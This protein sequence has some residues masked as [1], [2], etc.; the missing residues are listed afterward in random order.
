MKTVEVTIA[1]RTLKLSPLKLELV[2]S[3]RE[4]CD[5]LVAAKDKPMDK[6]WFKDVMDGVAF[7]FLCAKPTHPDLTL[8][9][10]E[11][12]IAARLTSAD[13]VMTIAGEVCKAL[14]ALAVL[15]FEHVKSGGK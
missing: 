13:N 6:A 12:E 2:P 5:R 3:A 10:L 14:D 15:T 1:D 8:S 4:T 7:I 9:E 11:N